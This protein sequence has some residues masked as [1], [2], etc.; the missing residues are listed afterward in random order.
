MENKNTFDGKVLM[1]NKQ[2]MDYMHQE[3]YEKCLKTLKEAEKFLSENNCLKSSELWGITYN[4]FGCVYKKTGN[5]KAA[6]FYLSKALE[7]EIKTS[8][9]ATNLASTHLNISAILSSMS[10]HENSLTHALAALK[11]LQTTNIRSTNYMV[12]V[13][14]A[15]HSIGVENEHLKKY[16]EALSAYKL[17]WEIAERELGAEH[18]LTETLRKSFNRGASVPIMPTVKST[19]NAQ[20]PLGN[21]RKSHQ[22]TDLPL[23]S[24]NSSKYTGD[25]K[26]S[27]LNKSSEG[28][29]TRKK[30]YLHVRKSLSPISGNSS[31]KLASEMESINR[32]IRELD[33][34][35][36]GRPRVASNL[37]SSHALKNVTFHAPDKRSSQTT[38][39]GSN[40]ETLNGSF[41]ET[42][43]SLLEPHHYLRV[44]NRNSPRNGYS[45]TPNSIP[46][47]NL[48]Q[49]IKKTPRVSYKH[50]LPEIITIQ[51]W[52]RKLRLKRRLPKPRSRLKKLPTPGVQIKVNSN[53]ASVMRNPDR[54]RILRPIPENKYEKKID[55]VIKIQSWWRMLQ[56]KHKFQSTRLS[57]I[58]IQ[59]HFRG[60]MTRSLFKLI[61]SAVVFIQS[62]YRGHRA[63]KRIKRIKNYRVSK[64]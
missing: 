27:H 29:V 47:G 18:K 33:G 46:K 17:G 16:S 58:T 26:N 12:S 35:R 62:V 48:K 43:E 6:L 3:D 31:I 54:G 32:L 36:E 10:R 59:K 21:K 23:L 37:V 49:V 11:T 39:Y 9:D 41:H 63:R 61:H 56:K 5:F 44:G 20:R 40:I 42:K 38:N 51:R 28:R 14:I 64:K 19:R 52:W 2:A 60:F 53:N 45:A 4:N 25:Q 1:M 34:N 8:Y 50:Y 13:V 24:G 22:C 57:A 15:Y 55:A 30:Y 7:M